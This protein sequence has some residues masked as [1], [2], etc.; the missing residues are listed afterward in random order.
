MGWRIR[1]LIYQFR[2]WF[3]ITKHK[4]GYHEYGEP[5][6]ATYPEDTYDMGEPCLKQRCKEYM[7][8]HEKKLPYKRDPNDEILYAELRPYIITALNQFKPETKGERHVKKKWEEVCL[9]LEMLARLVPA[10]KLGFHCAWVSCWCYF[11]S[12]KYAH[13]V[14]NSAMSATTE[15]ILRPYGEAK[16]YLLTKEQYE[17]RQRDRYNNIRSK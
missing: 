16:G 11:Y 2:K 4:F 9:E 17:Q 15:M 5:Y 3:A 12:S 10:N 8:S 6:L 14:H 7:C 13:K 1:R